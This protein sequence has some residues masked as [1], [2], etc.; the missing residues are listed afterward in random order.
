[1]L[2]ILMIENRSPKR[3][4]LKTIRAALGGPEQL[5]FRLEPAASLAA[6]LDK[7]TADS[8][9][10]ILLG[11]DRVDS[12]AMGTVSQ[13]RANFPGIPIFILAGA[14]PDGASE[15]ALR[16]GAQDCLL[17][18]ELEPHILRRILQPG[19]QRKR[20]ETALDAAGDKFTALLR[21]S[22]DSVTV[23][24]WT[25]GR[26]VELNDAFLHLS[27]YSRDEVAGKS[28]LDLNLWVNRADR[29]KI[30]ACLR[31]HGCVHEFETPFRAK[32]G[33]VR[34]CL[35]SAEFINLSG[36]DCILAV[37]RDTTENR[38]LKKQAKHAF[39]N[40]ALGRLAGGV[41]HDLNNWL[42]VIL[43]HCEIVLGKI[44]PGDPM[45]GNIGHIKSAVASAESLIERLLAV[46]GE[47]DKAP[48]IIDLNLTVAR[49]GK[50]LRRVL[51][52]NI[53]VNVRLDALPKLVKVFPAQ[54]EHALLNLALNA[55]DAMPHGGKLIFETSSL[56]I[57]ELNSPILSG[58]P[59]GGYALLTVSDT[60]TGMDAKTLAHVFDQLFTTKPP[61]RGTG[62][63]LC[64]VQDFVRE[65]GG[66]IRAQS[67]PGKGTAFRLAFPVPSESSVPRSEVTP[68][69]HS[70]C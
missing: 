67:E 17:L 20:M 66:F 49:V 32:S 14:D 53:E 70:A 33:D 13:L 15:Q 9:D 24:T 21:A 34:E 63:G 25:E 61:G 51:G 38:R 57:D 1:M 41:V 28:S 50:M 54:M 4:R 23:T 48:Q 5:S 36:A 2:E 68:S 55:R 62:L 31:A 42:T 19:I 60:G 27:G 56:D 64:T 47:M 12:R 6:G 58:M 40:D 7:F 22:S 46:G 44:S 59:I 11:T 39:R 35:V 3:S 18:D 26:F 29:I 10:A 43:G 52:E 37:V 8:Y 30:L 69:I 45:R 16:A 65:S